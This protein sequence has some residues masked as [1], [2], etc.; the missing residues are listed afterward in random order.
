MQKKS[1]TQ[2]GAVRKRPRGGSLSQLAAVVYAGDQDVDARNY[3]DHHD[4][5]LFAMQGVFEL[6]SK[7]RR[8]LIA[9]LLQPLLERLSRLIAI[10]RTGFRIRALSA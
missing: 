4:D 1:P 9:Q 8:N 3:D 6:A 7:I 5:G 2:G 10:P